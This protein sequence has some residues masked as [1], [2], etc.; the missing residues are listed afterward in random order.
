[1]TAA[2]IK[3]KKKFKGRE[4]R[5]QEWVDRELMKEK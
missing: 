1:M 5:L 2:E 4:R 3:K